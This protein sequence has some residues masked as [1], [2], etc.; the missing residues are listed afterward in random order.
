MG[1]RDAERDEEN[2]QK[3]NSQHRSIH[4]RLHGPKGIASAM[5]SQKAQID[6]NS[7]AFSD[8]VSSYSDKAR[9]RRPAHFSAEAER[10]G[11]QDSR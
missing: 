11:W 10:N 6:P 7:F 5:P 4:N 8:Y 9:T 3:G 2:R 1:S